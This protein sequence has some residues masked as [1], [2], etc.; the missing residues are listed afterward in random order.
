MNNTVRARSLRAEGTSIAAIAKELGVGLQWAYKLAS[1]ADRVV[2]PTSRT[3]VKHGAINGGCSTTSGL[4]AISM[5][6]I[7]AL[8]G[9]A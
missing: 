7:T 1:G 9:A 6:R 2:Q 8:H 4:L 5:P 3:V